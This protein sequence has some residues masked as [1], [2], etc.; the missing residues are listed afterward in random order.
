MASNATAMAVCERLL[1]R[2][3]LEPNGHV[4]VDLDDAGARELDAVA[5]QRGEAGQRERD[6]VGACSARINRVDGDD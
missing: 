6:G 2:G 3:P 4:R 1:D 5:F